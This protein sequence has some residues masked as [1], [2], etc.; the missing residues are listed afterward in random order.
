MTPKK[1]KTEKPAKK[2]KKVTKERTETAEVK[3]TAGAVETGEKKVRDEKTP[4]RASAKKAAPAKKKTAAV[5]A[6]PKKTV[7]A[8]AAA[9]KP[10]KETANIR[11]E[12]QAPVRIPSAQPA[13]VP[14]AV[15]P[16]ELPKEKKVIKPAEPKIKAKTAVVTEAKVTE[17]KKAAEPVK[18][19]QAAQPQQI[20]PQQAAQP[21]PQPSIQPKPAQ[22]AQPVQPV[23]PQREVRPA[24]PQPR[25]KIKIDETITVSALAN[26]MNVKVTELIKKML[27]MGIIA[28][29]NQR[30]DTDVAALVAAEFSY[31]V[32]VVPLYGEVENEKEED[33]AKFKPRSP[34]VTIMGHVDHGKT[35]LLDAIRKT[36]VAE[37]EFGGITQHIGAYKVKTPHGEIVFL[38]TPGHEAFTAMRARGAQVTDIVILIVAADDG[39]MPQTIEAIAHAK[40]AG[41]PII[42]AINKIDV[43]GVNIQKVK[44]EL[45]NQGLSPEDWGG[46]TITVEISARK[47]IGI[48]K[49]LDLILLQAE[50]LELKANPD[51]QAS[52]VVIEARI[53]KG[54]GPVATVLIKSGT[55]R[56]GD[57]FVAGTSYGK[58][59]AMRDDKKKHIKEA[60]PATPVEVIGFQTLPLSGD[61]FVVADDEKKARH[62]SE[63]RQ[64]LKRDERLSSKKHLT[65]ES[66]HKDFAEGKAKELNLI[67]KADVRGSAEVLRD[68][69]EKLSTKEVSVK[70]IH[71]GI[72]GI[73][74]SD[75]ILA[76]AS[77]AIIIGFNVRQETSAIAIAQRESVEI[78]TYRIIY[79]AIN[80]VKAAMEGLLEPTQKELYLGRA[81][82]LKVYKIE[83]IGNIAGCSVIDGKISRT[84]K[85]RLLRDNTIIFEGKLSSLKRFKD[86]VKEVEKGFECGLTLDGFND[87]KEGDIV[88]SYTFELVKRKL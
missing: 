70:I 12:V 16:Q 49:L 10:E 29:I 11:T 26:K 8:A 59:R 73:N 30:I 67:L 54:V 83:K 85:V 46:K 36:N 79:D 84:G 69:L 81:K 74:D 63:I 55:L 71:S 80:D 2:T 6:K 53:S 47:N 9:E 51:K 20:R 5:A 58:V 3:E 13:A 28:S 25:T 44:Q 35:S 65:L 19:Q 14:A 62:I 33:T 48:D 37:K 41:I 50:M 40:A 21:Q 38:D 82:I 72:G 45:A 57:Y 4:A 77:D 75:V 43:A 64:Q 78:K 18:P 24:A 87:I 76:A 1:Q 34:I 42:A 31:D 27:L 52:G 66:F 15:K 86:D 22:P 56:I 7:K 23:Q 61:K 39:V 68:S 88:E 32:E 60:G 17:I